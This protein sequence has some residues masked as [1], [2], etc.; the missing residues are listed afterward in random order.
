M[1]VAIVEDHAM[2]REAMRKICVTECRCEVVGEAATGKAAAKLIAE[3]RPEVLLLDLNLPEGDGFSVI[4]LTQEVSPTTRI[5]VLSSHCDDYTLHRVSMAQVQGFVDKNTQT[6][7]TLREAL[8]AVGRGQSYFSPAYQEA[9]RGR[10]ADPFAFMKLLSEREIEVLALIGQGLS[11]EE[12][13]R[14]LRL[15]AKTVETH[16]GNI[17]RKLDLHSTR[18]LIRFALE[19]GVAQ[20]PAKRGQQRVYC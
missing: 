19:S 12:V 4:A 14:Q 10:R 9:R 5:I 6:A 2:F 18:K 20:I 7:A 1:R 11:N 13:A 8:A 17:M 3:V 15:A 16:R